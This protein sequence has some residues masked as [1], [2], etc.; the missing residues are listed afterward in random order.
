MI[1][2]VV[3]GSRDATDKETIHAVLDEA[4]K[5]HDRI[6]LHHGG[7]R[8][9]DQIARDWAKERDDCVVVV[10]HADWKQFGNG[11]GMIRNCEMLDLAL[12]EANG[13]NAPIVCLAFPVEGAK[14]L[15]TFGCV[16][17]ARN[18]K[19]NIEVRMTKLAR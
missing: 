18:K 12:E 3:T 16:G 14:N 17:L 10:H 8:G 5:G 19:R 2:V 7:A 13:I 6:I 9:A 4:T 11:A 1:I 15:G